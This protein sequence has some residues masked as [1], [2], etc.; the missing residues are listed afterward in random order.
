MLTKPLDAL[1]IHLPSLMI[2]EETRG[3]KNGGEGGR[4][5]GEKDKEEKEEELDDKEEVE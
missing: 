3:E 2:C 1:K 5:S 4:A